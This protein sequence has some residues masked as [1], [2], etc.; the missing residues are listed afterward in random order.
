MRLL[1]PR[2]GNRR[3]RTP[4][5]VAALAAVIAG[6][7]VLAVPDQS[8]SIGSAGVVG[9]TTPHAGPGS[10]RTHVGG[11]N[12][13]IKVHGFDIGVCM[14]DHATG[15]TAFPDIYINTSGPTANCM[16]NVSVWDNAGH[17]LS[18]IERPCTAGRR[19]VPGVPVA[20]K[21]AA[22]L[23]TFARLDYT[24]QPS[25]PVGDSPPVQVSPDAAAGS[26]G[27]DV[28]Y[29][30]D[31]TL[32]ITKGVR[33]PA[34]VPVKTTVAKVFAELHRCFNCD[35]PVP[36]APAAYPRTGQAIN[37]TSFPSWV[38]SW[39]NIRGPILIYPRDN[40]SMIVVT[41]TDGHA[42]G[43]GANVTFR[44]YTDSS[45]TTHL[46]TT[47]VGVHIP[48]W[49]APRKNWGA[50]YVY[51][52]NFADNIARNLIAHGGGTAAL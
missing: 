36:G 51:W 43:V 8:S 37:L 20:P 11:C 32:K 22:V 21:A 30:F 25:I 15:T 42:D 17:R 50:A 35:F 46:R 9:Y 31:Y 41:A 14:D 18:A 13:H 29:D 6:A 16:I 38:P 19:S 34:S 33:I 26:G 7:V 49:Q 24:G 4:V 47:A 12:P 2:L 52:G 45:G 28:F 5:A 39:M 48:W 27:Q 40:E 1:I 3:W 23:H 44:F 10:N